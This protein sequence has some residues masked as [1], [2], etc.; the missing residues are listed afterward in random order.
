MRAVDIELAFVYH[1]PR[2]DQIPRYQAIRRAA[3]AYAR[4]IAAN[5]PECPEQST[6]LTLLQ[7]SVMMAN[8]GIAIREVEGIH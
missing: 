2:E 7:Q 5:T 8:A 6:S 4:A 1:P 3:L